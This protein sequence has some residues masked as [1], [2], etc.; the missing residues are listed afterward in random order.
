MSA[1]CVFDYSNNNLTY[2]QKNEMAK[3]LVEI[4]L[5][6]DVGV[7]FNDQ[8]WSYVID[9]IKSKEFFTVSSTFLYSDP[10]CVGEP[11]LFDFFDIELKSFN[12]LCIDKDKFREHFFAKYEFLTDFVNCLCRYNIVELS[13]LISDSGTEIVRKEDLEIIETTKDEFLNTLFIS[14]K[15]ELNNQFNYCFPTALF[16]IK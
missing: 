5:N 4:A 10:E 12:G 2:Q 6:D 7:L 3:E 16:M 9:I 14:L 15:D 1:L 8:N 11:S 13:V